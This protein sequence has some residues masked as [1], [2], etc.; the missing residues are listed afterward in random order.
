MNTNTWNRLRYSLYAPIYDRIVRPFGAS[1]KRSV[2]LLE[3]QADEKT[4]IVGAGTG[5]DLQFIP[6]QVEI[7][8]IDITPAMIKQV[9]SKAAYLHR[10]VQ[11]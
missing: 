5:E 2:E 8:A 3:L 10:S 7:T 6:E 9:R 4:L 1:R 11:A